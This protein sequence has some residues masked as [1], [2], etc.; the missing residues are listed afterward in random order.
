MRWKPT[1]NSLA[2]TLRGPH[3]RG[4]GTVEIKCQK[5][6]HLTPRGTA[7]AVRCRFHHDGLAANLFN[8]HN[9]DPAAGANDERRGSDRPTAFVSWTKNAD[10]GNKGLFGIKHGQGLADRA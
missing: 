10:M 5:R 9:D 1:F 7:P 8:Q 2:V 6:R 3:A 4:R